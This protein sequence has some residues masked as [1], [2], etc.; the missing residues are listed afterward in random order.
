MHDGR[1]ENPASINIA[2]GGTTMI[3]VHDT[4]G[5]HYGSV[6][7]RD[8]KVFHEPWEARTFALMFVSVITGGW[9]VDEVRHAIERMPPHEYLSTP[10][11]LH[12]L[13]AIERLSVR[14]GLLTPEELIERQ[15]VIRSGDDPPQVMHGES[16][17]AI[18]QRLAERARSMVH[19]GASARRPDQPQSFKSGDRVRARSRPVAG[20]TR[21]PRFVWG[22]LGTVVSYSGTF[23]LPDTMAHGREVS[24]EP[25]YSVRFQG[26]DLWRSEAE[27]NSSVVLDLYESYMDLADPIVT[28]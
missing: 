13:D 5:F 18:G 21:L 15:R 9:A 10:Y 17:P 12:W 20:H 2:I 22:N 14:D 3:G 16:D 26:R 6:Q 28:A 25:S 19:L 7:T 8:D 4:G 11:Y 1:R 27:S 24:I 23:P